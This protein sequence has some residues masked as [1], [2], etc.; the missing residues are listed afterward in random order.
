MAALALREPRVFSR[1]LRQPQVSSCSL[2]LRILLDPGWGLMC[3]PGFAAKP[4]QKPVK[5][6]ISGSG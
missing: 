3:L 1:G 2:V 6:A 4:R 5:E